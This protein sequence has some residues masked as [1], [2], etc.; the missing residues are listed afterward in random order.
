MKRLSSALYCLAQCL[1]VGLFFAFI[2]KMSRRF[3][4]LCFGRE[5][6]AMIMSTGNCILLPTPPDFI[7]I[8]LSC[9]LR[10]AILLCI[11][12][13]TDSVISHRTEMIFSRLF[14]TLILQLR[15]GSRA[16][17]YIRFFPTDFII[18]KRKRQ[19]FDRA[20]FFVQPLEKTVAPSCSCVIASCTAATFHVSYW[21]AMED[22]A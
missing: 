17:L 2:R 3:P 5:C 7:G 21:L 1:A 10:G 4:T 14:T 12:S 9:K 6:A 19:V 11:M 13:V 20:V 15:S 22:S 18:Q 8:T 16:D